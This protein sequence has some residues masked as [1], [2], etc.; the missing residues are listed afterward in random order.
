VIDRLQRQ[1]RLDYPTIRKHLNAL[2][3]RS[4]ENFYLLRTFADELE[5][6]RGLV[7]DGF[8]IS[9]RPPKTI[10]EN[11]VAFVAADDARL[12]SVVRDASESRNDREPPD[13]QLWSGA[14]PRM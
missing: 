9:E 10:D 14:W 4:V 5:K 2:T 7:G 12:R 8:G 11:F 3:G 6:K 13:C 1:W